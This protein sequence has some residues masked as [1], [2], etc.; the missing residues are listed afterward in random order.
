MNT[1]QHTPYIIV[2]YVGC[3]QVLILSKTHGR[4]TSTAAA[5]F[6]QLV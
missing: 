5:V 2:L 6:L 3:L 4:A 1:A